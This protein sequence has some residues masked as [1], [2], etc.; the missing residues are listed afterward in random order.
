MPA[1]ST[2]KVPPARVVRAVEGTRAKIQRLNQLIVPA[3]LALVEMILGSMITQGI[4]VAAELGIAD[5]IG[6]ES[7]T[8]EEIARRVGA[9]PEATYR[10]LR[11]LASYSIFAEGDDGR[12]ELTPM[13][14]ALREDAPISM[15]G[16]AR[17]MGH[18]TH[19][20]DWAHL[21]DSIRTGEP[22]LPKLRG[23][24]A[25][26]YLAANPEY[27]AIFNAGMGNL[28][29]LET[30]PVA[31]AYDFS[32]CGT[33]VDVGGGGGAL[34]AAILQRVGDAR[35]ILF[36]ERAV[37]SG[38]EATLK[39]AGVAERCSIEGGGLFDPVP[40]GGDAYLLKHI[41]HDWPEPKALEILRNVREGIAPDGRLL[42]MEFVIPDGKTQHIGKLVDLWLLLL[43]GGRDRT[44]A[45][46]S[47]LL[48]KAGF[49]LDRV[50]QTA[51][52]VSII[53]A[54]PE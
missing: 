45:Q 49:R 13:A 16:I 54:R 27:G 28:S 12:F 24:G 32:G 11:M 34:L 33:I 43:V 29:A 40:P 21:V 52:P 30:D 3:P 31:A 10:L 6:D 5:A 50:V 53:E 15:R 2:A 39:E 18:P 17:L 44:R 1:S 26:E 19:W 4:Y 47:E 7:L 20:E 25:F 51:A 8:A 22:S 38:A 37:A 14:E 46:Y 36:D 41:V 35:G 9:D 23:M 48:S 42:L